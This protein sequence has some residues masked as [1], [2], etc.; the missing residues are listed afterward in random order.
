MQQFDYMAWIKRRLKPLAIAGCIGL[1]LGAVYYAVWPHTYAATASLLVMRAEA[2]PVHVAIESSNTPASEEKEDY[3]ATQAG[4]LSSPLII[5]RALQTVG[6]ENCPTVAH[7]LE[8]V[9]AALKHLKVSRPDRTAK[10]LV[11]EYWAKSRREAT[12]TLAAVVQSY[13][14]YVTLDLYRDSQNRI[15]SLIE[16]KQG[17]IHSELDTLGQRYRDFIQAHPGLTIA[18]QGRSGNAERLLRWG[19][20][21]SDAELRQIRVSVQ[22][23]LAKSLIA[24]GVKNWGVA[25]ALGELGDSGELLRSIDLRT[26]QSGGNDYLR[27]LVA[28][29]QKVIE[30]LGASSSRALVL[31]EKIQAIQDRATPLNNAESREIVTSMEQALARLA[32]MRAQYDTKYNSD[33]K[34]FNTD[35]VALLEEESL[36]TKLDRARSMFNSLIDN[37]KQAQLN[38]EYNA[39][40]TSVLQIPTASL[41]SVSPKLSY[42]LAMGLVLGLVSGV[43]YTERGRIKLRPI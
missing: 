39:I 16:S 3:V 6:L 31:Q 42:S 10:I 5:Q 32:E 28:E 34:A 7:S 29:Q 43:L 26:M 9:D 23:A 20:A 41:H 27:A 12:A 19:A 35:E 15:V 33:L 37:L 2:R 17:D 36:K 13:T 25:Y 30:D 24:S 8:P 22:L 1:V 18:R 14:N 4:I 38:S 21:V 11:L 40:N